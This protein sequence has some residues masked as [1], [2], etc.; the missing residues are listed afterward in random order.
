ML[1]TV[2]DNSEDERV[3]FSLQFLLPFLFPQASLFLFPSMFPVF[4]RNN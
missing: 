1:A 4:C 2:A 3:L